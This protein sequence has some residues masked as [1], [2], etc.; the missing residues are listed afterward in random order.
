MEGLLVTCDLTL[1]LRYI[2]SRKEESL[3]ALIDDGIVFLL[4]QMRVLSPP[5]LVH[6]FFSLRQ[7]L[8]HLV[9]LCHKQTFD[10]AIH[11]CDS[12]Q[13][14]KP[15]L[16]ITKSAVSLLYTLPLPLRPTQLN[17]L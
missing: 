8:S 3:P 14:S 6:L 2:R 16:G 17:L 9:K 15:P 10:H 1:P 11:L 5:A 4:W 13:W 7:L 12:I